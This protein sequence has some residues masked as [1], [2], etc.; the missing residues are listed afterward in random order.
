M[1][2]GYRCTYLKFC[3]FV[4]YFFVFD[5][6]KKKSS[7]NI[8]LSLMKIKIKIMLTLTVHTWDC[9]PLFLK[10]M[11]HNQLFCCLPSSFY[12]KYHLRFKKQNFFFIQLRENIF[13]LLLCELT[14]WSI[15][16]IFVE[17]EKLL[18]LFCFS[19]S[20]SFCYNSFF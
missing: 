6:K 18:S 4:L 15:F 14:N 7:T 9:V 10:C 8:F 13:L 17:K 2:S 16:K 1:Y 12:Y 11:R 19:I 20:S 5:E 3:A